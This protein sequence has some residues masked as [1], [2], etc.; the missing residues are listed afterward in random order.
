M[1]WQMSR[2]SS[3]IEDRRGMNVPRAGGIGCLGL[4]V[5]L[6]ISYLTG[7]NPLELLQ[8]LGT[9]TSMPTQERS[10]APA[11]NDEGR[12]FV[13]AVLGSTEDEWTQIFAASGRQYQHPRLVLF[14]N[15]VSSACGFN[16]A[17]VGPFY[18]PSDQKVYLDLSFFQQL[19][20][21][22]GAS[23]DFA[24]AYVIAHE[25]GHHV[26]NLLGIS[27]QIDSARRRASEREANALS[28]LQELQA[29]C[30]AGVWG[31]HADRK[32]LLDAGDVEE[33]LNAAQA[34]GDDLLQKR[35]QGY[36]NRDSFTHGTSEQRAYWLRRGLETGR[37]DA[38]NTLKS[39]AQ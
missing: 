8:Q 32:D 25:V 36:V 20:Q 21:R 30:F 27:E 33:G 18:C 35:S 2:Q 7:S 38:C 14:E 1:R 12:Q 37:V 23:G 29:D 17:A 5:V 22:F 15:A 10:A 16:S 4:V 34:I 24:R 9:D 26:Q 13:A 19:S 6:V 31:H 39:G 28:V 11:G 3:N